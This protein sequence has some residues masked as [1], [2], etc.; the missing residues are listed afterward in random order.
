[1]CKGDIMKTIFT[2]I[3]ILHVATAWADNL[4]TVHNPTAGQL[5]RGEARIHQKMYKNNGIFLGADVG[6]FEIFQ[7]G[8]AYGAENVVGDKQ[9]EYLN[10]VEFK[11]RF[12]IIN[13]TFALPAFSLGVDTQGH[14]H[15]YKSDKRYD[16]MSKGAYLVASKNFNLLGLLG[17]D[18][19]VNYTFEKVYGNDTHLDAFIGMYKTIGE[20]VT[21]F[22]DWS[23]GFNDD[24]RE[25]NTIGKGRTYLNTGIQVQMT[26]NLSLKLLMYD[27]FRNRYEN[28]LFD[29]AL[30]LDYRW[31]F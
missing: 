18:L 7:F 29:R 22:A 6:L 11:G 23:G 17:F 5:A 26:D 8:V 13:E 21:V 16:I 19:G 9:P 27:M 20:T 31:Q 15:Y 30:I 1:M 12:R 24:T 25:N 4:Y 3:L 28:E 10:R 14:G 2:F